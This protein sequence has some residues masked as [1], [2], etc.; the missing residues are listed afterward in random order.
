MKTALPLAGIVAAE[1]EVTGEAAAPPVAVSESGMGDGRTSSAAV[2]PTFVTSTETENCWRRSMEGGTV[3]R[4]TAI[5][6]GTW[7]AM[8]AESTGWAETF[9]R[10][11]TSVPKAPACSARAPAPEP[12]S[13]KV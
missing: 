6:A 1:G 9:A 5:E 8:A 2:P 13:T 10:E 3:T 11:F 12:F 7:T 4:V